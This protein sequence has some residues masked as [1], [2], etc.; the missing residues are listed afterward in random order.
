[1][2]VTL[3]Q[4]TPHWEHG[5]QLLPGVGVGMI[6]LYGVPAVHSVKSPNHIQSPPTGGHAGSQPRHRHRGHKCPAV[7]L[8]IIPVT[9]R[10]FTRISCHLLYSKDSQNSLCNRYSVI[11]VWRGTR[12][13]SAMYSHFPTKS[14]RSK[15]RSKRYTLH[16]GPTWSTGPV[17]RL[18]HP[19]NT[20]MNKQHQPL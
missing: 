5:R 18:M 13:A 10:Q 16:L 15:S 6:A 19:Y 17:R 4:P 11:I 3:T 2:T 9:T 20:V 14:C 1:M 7:G 8:R 12:I